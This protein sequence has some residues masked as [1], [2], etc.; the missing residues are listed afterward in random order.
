VLARDLRCRVI[1]FNSC[2]E[3]PLS[4]PSLAEVPRRSARVQYAQLPVLPGNH[5]QDPIVA[6]VFEGLEFVRIC[7]HWVC[8][9][10]FSISRRKGFKL[11]GVEMADLLH[12]ITAQ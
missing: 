3:M 4:T 8:S 2:N 6:T 12:Q 5:P 7:R 9:L 10:H 1:E 11:P